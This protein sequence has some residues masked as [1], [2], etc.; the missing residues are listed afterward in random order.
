MMKGGLCYNT[1]SMD[2]RFVVLLGQSKNTPGSPRLWGPDET[3][4]SQNN[5]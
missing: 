5:G 4:E 3:N 2:L 1:V